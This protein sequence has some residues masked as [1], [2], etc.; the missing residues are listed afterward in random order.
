[1]F[2]KKL[3]LDTC[4]IIWLAGD[5]KELSKQALDIIQTASVVY[6]SPISAWEISLKVAHKELKLP[7][8][9]LRWF[10]SVM[11]FYNYS[12]AALLLYTVRAAMV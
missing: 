5:K 12:F 1:M 10:E 2:E 9:P 4:A 8:E 6:V 3:L 7:E 11:S